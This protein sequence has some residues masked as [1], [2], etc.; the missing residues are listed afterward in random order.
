MSNTV[1]AFVGET[2]DGVA[3]TFYAMIFIMILEALGAASASISPQATNIANEG[4]WA[5]VAIIGIAG[6]IGFIKLA[7]I[8]SDALGGLGRDGGYL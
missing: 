2:I 1:Q 7:Q 3:L 4:I 5:I 8:L 6:I